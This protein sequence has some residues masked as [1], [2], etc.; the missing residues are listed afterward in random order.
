MKIINT[1]SSTGTVIFSK[2][3]GTLGI[4]N[5]IQLEDGAVVTWESKVAPFMRKGSKVSFTARVKEQEWETGNMTVT[6]LKIAK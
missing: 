1:I 5:R 2:Q 4:T 3:Y 6:H